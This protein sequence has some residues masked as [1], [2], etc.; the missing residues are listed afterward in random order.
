MIVAGAVTGVAPAGAHAATACAAADPYA[1]R[2]V[3]PSAAV[4]GARFGAAAVSGDF[5]KDGYADVAVGAPGDTVGGVA[6]GSVT[7]FKGSAGGLVTPGTRLTESNVGGGIEAGDRFGAALAAGD[8]NKD[9]YADLAVGAPGEA[10][11]TAAGAGAIAV[12]PGGSGGLSGGRGYDQTTGGGG[13][14]AGDN[15]GAALAAG[16]M[17]GD[18]YADLAIGVPGEVPY[19]ET[20]KGGSIYVYKG[21]AGGVVKGWDAK[22]EDAGGA[23]E[24]GDRFGAAL[25]AGNVTGSAHADL[26]VGAPAEA[27][28]ADPAGSGGVYVIPGAAAGKAAGFGLTQEGNGGGNEAGDNFGATLATGNFDRDGYTDVAVGVPGEVQGAD[29]KSGSVVIL[30]GAA[31]KLGTAFW[32]QESGAAEQAASGDRFGA[33]L[34]TGDADGNGH[35]DLVIGAP[36]KAYGAA[37]AGAAFLFRGGAPA[38][39]STA[40]LTTGRRVTQTDAGDVAEGGD[41]FGSAAALG[42]LNKDGKAEAVV[43]SPGE[44]PGG[45]PASGTAV[46]LS[47]LVR[48][49]AAPVPL[50]PYTPTAALQATPVQGATLGPLEYAYTDNIG[51]LLH[52]HQPDPDNFGSVQWTVISGT[53]AYAGGPA[54]GEQADG[55]LQIAAHDSAGPVW[56]VTQATKNTP[57]WEAWRPGDIAM[58]SP[59]VIGKLEDGRPVA[60]AVDTAGL[61]W[62]LPQTAAAGPYTSWISLGVAGLSGA[63][64]VAA[65]V[66]GGIRLFVLDSAGVLRTMV[67]ANGAVTGC[68]SISDPGL[69]ATPA[70]V[71][72]PGSRIRLFVRGADGTVLTKRQDDTGAFPDAWEQVPGL[73]AA[74]RPSALLSPLS[75]KTEIVA[76]T[77]DGMIHSTGETVQ[78]SGT[79]RPWQQVTFAGDES[80]TDPTAFAFSNAGGSSW[81]FLYRNADHQTRVYQVSTQLS[82]LERQE[83]AAVTFSREEVPEPPK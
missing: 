4:A 49:A 27:P 16:D 41:N 19:Q 63:T 17:N 68:T 36:G 74:G 10:I 48:T 51:R 72:Y 35:S 52:G 70:A 50:E 3:A 2:V 67:Y 64:P 76:R 7:V 8:F 9:G 26:V 66:S 65:T 40:G 29:V 47:G 21:S 32:L 81:A 77:A 46:V 30:P 28:G 53:E 13:D 14:E 59:P 23:T 42:D 82:A 60:F 57:A 62:A 75:G 6:G 83:G 56:T 34:A 80:A 5:N 11:G 25:A 71:V 69:T 31:T 43:G 79:W 12:F 20:A 33:A 78:G 73:T 61:L 24:A 58:A 22:Q 18:G 37:G 38:A 44:G 45:G 15:F 39:G 55:R 1:H 54:L